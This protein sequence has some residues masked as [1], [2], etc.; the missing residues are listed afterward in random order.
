MTHPRAL[1][2]V[3]GCDR[4][5]AAKAGGLCAG[6]AYRKRHPELDFN[7]PFN[8]ALARRQSTLQTLVQA[9]IA[10][11]DIDTGDDRAWR[12]G[13]KRLAMASTRHQERKQRRARRRGGPRA[14]R[15]RKSR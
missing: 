5:E 6:H 10:L 9:A 4:A 3:P 8:E 15:V 12:R 11:G 7:A 1:C 2:S 14:Q 13:V